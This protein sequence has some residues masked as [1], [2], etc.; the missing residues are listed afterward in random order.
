MIEPTELADYLFPPAIEVRLEDAA[1]E[2]LFLH[3]PSSTGRIYR[4]DF[5]IFF[6]FLAEQGLEHIFVHE[7]NT[8]HIAMFQ[9]QELE[10]G[11][12]PNTVRR[13]IYALRSFYAWAIAQKRCA[14]SNPAMGVKLPKKRAPLPEV[15]SY[16]EV[17][18]LIGQPDLT[19]RKGK[20][21][22]AMLSV[23]YYAGLRVSEL[24]RLK[25]TSIGKAKFP[26]KHRE[27]DSIEI[28]GKGGKLRDV[29]LSKNALED[30]YRW[31][32]A[33]PDYDTDYLFMDLRNGEPLST[34]GFRTLFFKYAREAGI[35]IDKRKVTPHT[36][37]HS[38]ATHLARD[39]ESIYN[40]QWLLGHGSIKNTEIYLHLAR[41][42]LVNA[43]DRLSS[44]KNAGGPN[45]WD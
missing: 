42:D 32:K 33:R 2:W 23:T 15:L 12:S 17:M 3:D 35:D 13:R 44:R 31:L 37:R 6:S 30:L 36:L 1:E 7:L 5:D 9:R 26:H 28:E 45:I 25:E 18:R 40:I 10:R 22:R 38:F 4:K 19:T 39:G 34:Y 14:V 21:D 43:V 11:L 41:E 27:R 24:C 8:T 29:P 16:D 20:R